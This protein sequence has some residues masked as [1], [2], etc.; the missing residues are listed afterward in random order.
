MKIEQGNNG[1]CRSE[2]VLE[3][4]EIKVDKIESKRL[5]IAIILTMEMQ[6]T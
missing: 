1:T 3:R 2:Q 4:K 6:L 5:S